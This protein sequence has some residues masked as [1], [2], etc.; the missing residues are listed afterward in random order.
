MTTITPKALSKTGST[1]PR[2]RRVARSG[3]LAACLAA[4]SASPWASA[5]D[6]TPDKPHAVAR[7]VSEQSALV[8]GETN[9][10][11]V[12]ITMDP[13]WH[14][15]WS[16][17]LNALPTT[18]RTEA[19]EG[20]EVAT[21]IFPAPS[22]HIMPGGILDY[23]Y[24][25]EVTI[26]LPVTVPSDFAGRAVSFDIAADWLVCKDVCLPGGQKLS[27]ELPVVATSDE[28]R[29]TADA[30]LFARTRAR[31]PRP[32]EQA[33]QTLAF[34]WSG[35]ELTIEASR[36][37]TLRF[38]PYADAAE[39]NDLLEAGESKRGSLTI[40]P[41]D[42][43]TAK[44]VAGIIELRPALGGPPRLFEVTAPVGVDP[45]K[46]QARTTTRYAASTNTT[47]TTNSTNSTTTSP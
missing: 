22:R 24:E 30:R 9:H 2:P 44:P 11:G 37:G 21:P 36:G 31:L 27:V 28:T 18:V 12:S 7:V 33:E 35:S 42:P 8:A 46:H 20:V 3:L 26:I 25:D 4:A 5:Q 45:M 43:N 23:I 41:I 40:S 34:A 47:N 13:H 1:P 19:T 6:V 32:L 29:P 39:L 38:F 16:D 17:E 15:Y 14:I 10:I